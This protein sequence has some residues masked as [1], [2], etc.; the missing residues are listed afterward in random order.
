[1]PRRAYVWPSG[2]RVRWP[3][4]WF[5]SRWQG[6]VPPHCYRPSMPIR[7]SWDAEPEPGWH[8]GRGVGA[9]GSIED[10]HAGRLCG[11]EQFASQLLQFKFAARRR[12][13]HRRDGL[14]GQRQHGRCRAGRRPRPISATSIPPIRRASRLSARSG[15]SPPWATTSLRCLVFC[16]GFHDAGRGARLRGGIHRHRYGRQHDDGVFRREQYVAGGTASA[17]HVEHRTELSRPVAS[18]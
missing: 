10:R 2:H 13:Q 15:C 9:A 14:P 4:R 12:V 11:A 3:N 5:D 6:Q 8:A 7:R 1:M 16:C 17:E 18:R